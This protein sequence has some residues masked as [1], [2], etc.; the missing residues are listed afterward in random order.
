MKQLGL[1]V[2]PIAGMGGRVG[3]KGTDGPDILAEA[4]ARGA[5]PLSPARA[6]KAMSTL[7]QLK[8]K[9]KVWT[10]PGDMGEK[11]LKELE[12]EY[13]VIPL[14]LNDGETSS[15]DT[16]NAAR[17]LEKIGV[18][19]IVFVGGD[20]TARDV[21][22]AID[23]SL[24]VLGVPA[25]VK[26]HSGVF[27]NTPA[28]AGQVLLNF[29]RGEID[30]L[31]EAEVMDIDEAAFREG[32]VSAKLFGYLKIPADNRFIQGLKT[33]VQEE[34]QEAILDG[35]AERIVED[36]QKGTCFFIGPGTT[37]RRVM[38]KLELEYTL[39]GVDV[40]KDGKLLALDVGE[41][42]ILSFQEK[43]EC[44]ILVTPI[45]GQGFVFGR[46]NQQFSPE[47]LRK[48]GKEDIIII[49][50]KS[51]L[52]SIPDG[53]LKIDTGEQEIDQK[54]SGFYRVRIGYQE[55]KVYSVRSTCQD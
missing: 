54:F 4:R 46:G 49:A 27:A 47:V 37:T 35:I 8:D 15:D 23:A 30:N 10:C 1:I 16:V 52:E 34:G 51:K 42:D 25:G 53:K 29:F 20:G 36:M 6:K 33:G 48:M 9:V 44:K 55:E 40:V 45:G 17:E 13:E 31:V 28:D 7:Q 2:N 50:S 3:L 39:L 12:L 24:P 18:D 43:G 21:F 19:L 41:K 14:E 32:R 22:K 11:I 38:E 26:I 5:Q